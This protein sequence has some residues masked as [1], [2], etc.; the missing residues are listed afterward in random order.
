MLDTEISRRNAL[1]LFG[2]TGAVAALGASG[3]LTSQRVRA[4]DPVSGGN[5]RF[6]PNFGPDSLD[7]H[8]AANSSSFLVLRT[9]VTRSSCS[10]PTTRL[11]PVPRRQWTTAADG[12]S[13]TF[14]LRPRRDVPRRD[15]FDAEAVKFNLDRI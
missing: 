13:Y 6:A 11:P 12:L 2:L 9:S 10:A 1:R 14:K 5:F 7:P 3:F 4:Q 15:P 8:V